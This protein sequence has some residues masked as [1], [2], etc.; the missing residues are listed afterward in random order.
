MPR[1]T[2]GELMTMAR[3]AGPIAPMPQTPLPD[4]VV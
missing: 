3:M 1:W 2:R 4:E